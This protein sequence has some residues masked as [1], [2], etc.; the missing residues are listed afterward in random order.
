MFGKPQ[1]FSHNLPS[2][3]KVELGYKCPHVC[4][5]MYGCLNVIASV[6]I[7]NGLFSTFAVTVVT[8][9]VMVAVVM[10]I[11]LKRKQR[12]V[13]QRTVQQHTGMKTENRDLNFSFRIIH[14]TFIT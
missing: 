6:L 5:S 8:F 1:F 11:S 3:L 10:V 14:H 13:L 4:T 12:N 9:V 7:V 2:F